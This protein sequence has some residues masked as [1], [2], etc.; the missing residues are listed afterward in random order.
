MKFK[1]QLVVC[2]EDG[3]E[4]TVP[5]LTVLDK[6]CQRIEH[7]SLTLKVEW[8][9]S[10]S[11]Q[12]WEILYWPGPKAREE[13]QR[14][15]GTVPPSYRFSGNSSPQSDEEEARLQDLLDQIRHELKDPRWEQSV[16]FYRSAVQRLGRDLV[17]ARLSETRGASLEGK[18]RTG[19]AA[20]FID[21]LTRD[22]QRHMNNNGKSVQQ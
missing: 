20:Y 11:K 19:K 13:L 3:R 9:A 21:L 8:Q 12:P 4:E 10:Q 14:A 22:L 2:A 7:P 18:I 1:V 6:D 16:P 5:D 15:R 17:Y